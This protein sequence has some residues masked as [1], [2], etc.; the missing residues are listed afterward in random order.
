MG[1][2]QRV[3]QGP[4]AEK[5]YEGALGVYRQLRRYP[6]FSPE[7]RQQLAQI[8]RLC[9][10]AIALNDRHG[11]AHILLANTYLLMHH[12][13]YSPFGSTPPLHLAA[14]VIQHWA[15]EPMRQYPWTKNV[16]NGTTM[17]GQISSALSADGTSSVPAEMG[18][19]KRSL[20]TTAVSA[21]TVH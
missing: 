16:D 1:F 15:D 3:K 2:F 18:R 6:V 4:K 9:Q 12:D 11:D 10:Q 21:S 19:L 8:V 5:A 13:D 14:A 7:Y 17:H 20:Y